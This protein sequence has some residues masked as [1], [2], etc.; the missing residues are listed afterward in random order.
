MF[1]PYTTSGLPGCTH[2][3]SAPGRG[4]SV[5]TLQVEPPSSDRSNRPAPARNMRCP[6]VLGATASRRGLPPLPPSA[7]NPLACS[8]VHVCPSSV[9][10]K[11]APVDVLVPAVPPGGGV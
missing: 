9:D 3:R 5:I 4:S 11:I 7:G 8:A 2:T 1:V 6:L 10:L